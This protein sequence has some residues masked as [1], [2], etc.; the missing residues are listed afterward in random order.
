MARRSGEI[1]IVGMPARDAHYDFEAWPFFLSEKRIS[2]SLFGTA[3]IRRDFPRYVRLAESGQLDL[4]S[5]IT[6]TISLGEVNDGLD[7]LDRGS[8]LRA[9][10]V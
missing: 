1:I 10:I 3:D 6:R 8:V 5:L 4:K 9:V 7:A 2:S